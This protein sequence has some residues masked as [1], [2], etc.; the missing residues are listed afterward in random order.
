MFFF[1]EMIYNFLETQGKP[2]FKFK[3]RAMTEHIKFL[4][5]TAVSLQKS[6]WVKAKKRELLIPRHLSISSFM[7]APYHQHS[8]KDIHENR[9]KCSVYCVNVQKPIQ[10]FLVNDTF[11]GQMFEPAFCVCSIISHIF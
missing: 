3:K 1:I 8:L 2:I 4:H 7:S 11:E 5:V 9:L 10:L 6:W